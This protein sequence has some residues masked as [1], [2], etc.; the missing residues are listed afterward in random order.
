MA[1]AEM[2]T[3]LSVLDALHPGAALLSP[4]GKVLENGVPRFFRRLAQGVFD[5]ADL[6]Y[7]RTN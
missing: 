4:R 6:I 5:E 3:I 7:E 1:P 2:K